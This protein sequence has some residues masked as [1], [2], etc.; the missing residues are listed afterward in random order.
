LLLASFL[1]SFA[2]VHK[3]QNLFTRNKTC[4]RKIIAFFAAA[5][6]LKQKKLINVVTRILMSVTV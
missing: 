4:Q 3:A 1:V 6:V 5:L 2:T